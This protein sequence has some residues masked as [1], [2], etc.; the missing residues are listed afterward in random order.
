MVDVLEQVRSYWD[1]DAS[2]YDRSPGHH[3]CA[4]AE[5]D[6]WRGALAELLASPPG[7]VLDVGAGTGFLSL[8][9]AAA[10]YDVTALDLSSGML[11]ELARK[12]AAAGHDVHVQ[13]GV[14]G[15]PPAGPFDAVIE[16]H[17]LWTLPDPVGALAAWR[18]VAPSGRL[19]L[20]ESCW[21]SAAAPVERGRAALRRLIA[22][23]RRT[24]AAHHAQYDAALRDS[25]PL[26]RGTSP[27]ALR[28]IVLAAGWTAVELHWL[29]DLDRAAAAQRPIPERWLGVT[30]RFALTAR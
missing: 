21:G 22:R 28:A 4:D 17:V 29:T 24:P 11:A 3:P 13:H 6:A 15:Q 27:E 2:T 14:A 7:C 10:G 20:F 19:V 30:P 18:Q 1:S 26:G 23:A 8:L 12:A 5:L 16:R 25:L 9:A